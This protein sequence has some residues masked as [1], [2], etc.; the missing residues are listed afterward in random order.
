M[1]LNIKETVTSDAVDL[2]EAQAKDVDNIN[3]Q[4]LTNMRR[5]AQVGMALFQTFGG[6]IDQTYGLILESALLAIE[7]G[8]LA[9]TLS[10]LQ[11]LARS[12]AIIS[13][14]TLVAQIETGRREAITQTQA[15]VSLFRML[16]FR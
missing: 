10:P 3:A 7:T 8:V 16:T 4:M 15:S 9:S 14:L 13:L 11:L 12:A 5:T 1:S 2:A 6:A